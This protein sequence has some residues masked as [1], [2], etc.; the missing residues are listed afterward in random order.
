MQEM[1]REQ[2]L[3]AHKQ[4]IAGKHSQRVAI[5]MTSKSNQTSTENECQY[6][7]EIHDPL[8]SFAT[9]PRSSKAEFSGAEQ[10]SVDRNQVTHH[11]DGCSRIEN[12]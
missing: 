12:E 8:F 9:L 6:G 4:G 1:D 5:V 11:L 7:Q 2:H 3:K 10:K